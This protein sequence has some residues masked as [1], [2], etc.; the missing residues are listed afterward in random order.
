[1]I[2]STLKTHV[3][4]TLGLDE[5]NTTVSTLLDNW[6]NTIH[7]DIASRYPWS[8]L[9]EREVIRTEIDRTTGTVSVSAND[10]A[11]TGSGTSFASTDIGDFIQFSSDND[12]YE[13]SA[14]ASATALTLTT[15]YNPTSAL[16]A[17]TYTIR[18]FFYSLSSSVDDIYDMNIWVGDRKLHRI[19]ARD[20]DFWRP[21]S[22]GDGTPIYYIPWNQD[23]SGNMQF[24]LYPFPDTRINIEARFHKRSTS[25]SGATNP[26]V[27]A[28]WDIALIEG[29]LWLGY[30]FERKDTESARAKSNYE[31]TIEDMR[32]NDR[33]NRDWHPVLSAIDEEVSIGEPR[34]PLDFDWRGR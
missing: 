13:I 22:T 15:A 7:R 8:F 6:I 9:E 19:S 28:K 12:W 5:A 23:S 3:A 20:F 17:G 4:N 24:T 29:S 1:M 26:D 30:Q 16:S 21:A 27:P 11:V 34:L 14:V 31:N 18:T 10:T 33:R 2:Y 25:L 32:R